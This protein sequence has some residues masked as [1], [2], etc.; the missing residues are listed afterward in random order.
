M[1]YKDDYQFDF[2][3]NNGLRSNSGCAPPMIEHNINPAGAHIRKI[4][5][6]NYVSGGLNKLEGLRFFDKDGKKLL[7]LG[8]DFAKT[9]NT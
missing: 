1:L 9:N 5:T 2:I 7:E 4:E 6:H 3:F 8:R